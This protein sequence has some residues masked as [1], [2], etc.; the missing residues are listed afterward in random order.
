MMALIQRIRH[1]L[2]GDELELHRKKEILRFEILRML[3]DVDIELRTLNF[4]AVKFT[5]NN[6]TKQLQENKS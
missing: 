6:I 5:I 3:R 4:D 1:V 2:N